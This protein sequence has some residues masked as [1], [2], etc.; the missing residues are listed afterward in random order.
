MNESQTDRLAGLP[1]KYRSKFARAYSGKS[2]AAAIAAKCADCSCF[3]QG[4][5]THCTVFNCPLWP[6][7]P[8]QITAKARKAQSCAGNA[9]RNKGNP[10]W[11][12]GMRKSPAPK[13]EQVELPVLGGPITPP[14]S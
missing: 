8:Y 2:K 11:K 10:N 9:V 12:P 4:E 1:R 3:Q 14:P 7:R 5:I 6:Y 13:P